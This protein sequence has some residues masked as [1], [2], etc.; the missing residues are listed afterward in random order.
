M[1]NATVVGASIA[2]LTA[3]LALSGAGYEVRVL[4]RSAPPPEG[5]LEQAVR[6]WHRPTL[7]QAVHSHTLTS[8]GVRTLRRRA[9]QLLTTALEAGAELL[10]LLEALPPPVEN[11]AR[12]V[13]DDDLVA[14]ACRRSVLELLLYRTVRNLPQVRIS[15]GTVVRGLALDSSGERVLG[16]RTGDG[17][18][19]PASVVIDATGRRAESRDWLTAAGIPVAEDLVTPS[20]ITGYSRQ[21]RL[22]DTGRPGPLNRGNATGGVWDHYAA[23]L[24]PADN[25]TFAV[26]VMVPPGDHATAR[27]REPGAFTAAA[28]ATPGL[29]AWLAPGVSDPLTPV[30]VIACPPNTLRGTVT[31]RQ[32][33]VAGLFA[34]GDAACVTNP[35]YGRGM[36]L[37]MDHAFQLAD[38]LAGAAPDQSLGEAAA[39]LAEQYFTPWYQLA[40]RDDAQRAAQWQ[41]ATSGD[42]SPPQQPGGGPS[43]A[44]VRAAA[45]TDGLVW[46]SVTRVIMGLSTPAEAFGDEKFQARVEQAPPIDPALLPAAP[47]REEF[48]RL[49]AATE[50]A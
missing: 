7:P 49:I 45:L 4:E 23:A 18:V 43:P 20:A 9:P 6:D 26:A 39:R 10:D 3:A 25:H 11:R 24:H 36:S 2:G 22:R 30:N 47:S 44:Q 12:E 14:L 41:A 27:L 35:L 46:R 5:P 50:G 15:H 28:R 31:T 19:L 42:R 17:E 32:R 48:L 16:V 21:Y 13:G 37:A 40:A 34:V 33:P 8:V 1:T 29:G 38:L